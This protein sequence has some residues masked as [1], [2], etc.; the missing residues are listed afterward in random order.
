M[1]V[2][3]RTGLDRGGAIEF[4][5]AILTETEGAGVVVA[6]DVTDEPGHTRVNDLKRRV[7]SL[8]ED[9]MPIRVPNI[10]DDGVAHKGSL[11]GKRAISHG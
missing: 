7:F 5:Q 1:E 10:E 9:Q 11:I 2:G 8:C 4:E 3:G 6:E